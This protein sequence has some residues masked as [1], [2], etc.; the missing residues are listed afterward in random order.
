VPALVVVGTI[1]AW[2]VVNLLQDTRPLLRRG[3]IALMA[4][5]CAFSVLAQMATGTLVAAQT[6]RGPE[7]TSYL[8]LQERLSG[9]PDSAVARLVTSS[10]TLPTGGRADELHIVGDC[11]ALY[12]NT[13]DQYEPWNLVEQRRMEARVTPTFVDYRPG[14]F[15]LFDQKGLEPRQVALEFDRGVPQARLV[16]VDPDGNFVSPW[17]EVARGRTIKV[18]AE[19]VPELFQTRLRVD[20]DPRFDLY[21]PVAEWNEDWYNEPSQLAF[22]DSRDAGS[23]DHA[24]VN[25]IWGPV[26]ELCGRLTSRSVVTR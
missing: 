20:D 24:R 22:V 10:P 2:H 7:L 9:G 4:A 25:N 8:S 13:G 5:L 18:T 3:F 12:V 21:L 16:V 15:P 23:T 11:A 19:A 17:F 6:H 26:P 1:G 14:L